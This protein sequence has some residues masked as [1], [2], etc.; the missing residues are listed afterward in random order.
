MLVLAGGSDGNLRTMVLGISE[1][2][3]IK[4]KTVLRTRMR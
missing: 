2:P 3:V 1:F 4:I